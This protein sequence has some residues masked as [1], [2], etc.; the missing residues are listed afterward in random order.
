MR[1]ITTLI[2]VVALCGCSKGSAAN[3]PQNGEPPCLKIRTAQTA[4]EKSESG[5]PCPRVDSEPA[6]AA[7]AAAP[8]EPDGDGPGAPESAE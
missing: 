2:G 7:D 6:R 1:R 3:A 4:T 5:E 8:E